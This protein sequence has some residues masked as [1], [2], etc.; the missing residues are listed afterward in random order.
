MKL[1]KNTAKK[2]VIVI[3]TLLYRMNMNLLAFLVVT[4]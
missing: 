4:M 2:A 3:E 1:Y